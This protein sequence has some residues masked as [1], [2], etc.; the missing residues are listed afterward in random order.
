V[1]R[2]FP[3]KAPSGDFHAG[4]CAGPTV[5]SGRPRLVIVSEPPRSPMSSRSARHLALNSVTLTIRCLTI[6]L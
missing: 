2:T 6:L 5:A 4:M 3:D 1:I